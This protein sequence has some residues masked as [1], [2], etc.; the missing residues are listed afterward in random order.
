MHVCAPASSPLCVH[1]RPGSKHGSKHGPSTTSAPARRGTSCV[2]RRLVRGL[3]DVCISSL[4]IF[5]TGMPGG[6]CEA[7]GEG[8]SRMHAHTYPPLTSERVL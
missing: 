4:F 1:A 7:S 8:H 2:V 6:G 3:L 5:Q